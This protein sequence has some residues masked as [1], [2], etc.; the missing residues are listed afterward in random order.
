MKLKSYSYSFNYEYASNLAES[1]IENQIAQSWEL[2]R[3]YIM[4]DTEDMMHVIYHNHNIEITMH[5][6]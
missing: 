5:W 1:Q 6:N 3:C 4:A 2:P